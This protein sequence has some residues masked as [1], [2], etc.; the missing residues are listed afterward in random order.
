MRK[1]SIPVK[2]KLLEYRRFDVSVEHHELDSNMKRSF[3]LQAA[4]PDS[5]AAVNTG[6]P[7]RDL[8]GIDNP[9]AVCHHRVD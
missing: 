6:Y 3:S 2:K 8:I 9:M 5:E 4:S 1:R 7:K